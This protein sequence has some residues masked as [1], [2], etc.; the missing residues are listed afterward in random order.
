MAIKN[1]TLKVYNLAGSLIRT[2]N[3]NII[4]ND[5][6]FSAQT[7]GGQGEISL[8]LAVSIDSTILQYNNIIK[9]YATTEAYPTGRLIYTGIVGSLRRKAEGGAVYIEARIVGLASMFAWV[10][11][12]SGANF[13]FTASADP[14][15]TAKAIV[16][17]FSAVYP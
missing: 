16:D 4:M 6:S 9:I 13:T 17:R 11:H 1:L 10:L 15:D 14:A 3:P 5:L 2:L 7:E 8:K 12:K